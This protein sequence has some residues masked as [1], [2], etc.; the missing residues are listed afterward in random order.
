M[1][2]R[3]VALNGISYKNNKGEYHREDGPAF[4]DTADGYQCWCLNGIPLRKSG[5]PVQIYEDGGRYWRT[6]NGSWTQCLG[7]DCLVDSSTLEVG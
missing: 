2:T 6:R 7:H 3:T 5:N 1:I 4:I